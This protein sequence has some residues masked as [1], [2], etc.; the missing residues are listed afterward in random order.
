MIRLCVSVLFTLV[1]VLSPFCPAS[2]LEKDA[3]TE[4]R[5]GVLLGMRLEKAEKQDVG[6]WV[7]TTGAELLLGNGPCRG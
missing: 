6:I 7:V 5:S 4:M 1:L 3:S 2:G